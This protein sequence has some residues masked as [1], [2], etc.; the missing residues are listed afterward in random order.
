[1]NP[2]AEKDVRNQVLFREVNERVREVAD[3]FGLADDHAQ[4]LCECGDLSCSETLTLTFEEYDSG[5]SPRALFLLAPGHQ[6]PNVE[7]VVFG[8]AHFLVV[9]RLGEADMAAERLARD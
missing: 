1:V 7:R 3:I 5:R 2:D 6:D 9:E 8:H 4:F